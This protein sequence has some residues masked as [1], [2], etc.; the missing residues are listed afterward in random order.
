[1]NYVIVFFND[2]TC[3]ENLTTFKKSIFKCLPLNKVV[4]VNTKMNNITIF[5]NHGKVLKETQLEV[6]INTEME[7]SGYNAGLKYLYEHGKIDK[8]IVLNDTVFSHGK[9]RKCEIIALIEYY[10]LSILFNRESKLKE[11]KNEKII[12]GFKHTNEFLANYDF[13]HEYVNSKFFI[14]KNIDISDFEE[15]NPIGHICVEVINGKYKNNIY[16]YSGYNEFLSEWLNG[17]KGWYKA[18][19]L[20]NSNQGFFI[21]KAKSI[22]HEH[23]MSDPKN[24]DK[25]KIK[26]ICIMKKSILIKLISLLIGFKY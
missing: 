26:A 22:V 18:E 17:E 13:S 23:F 14:L 16:N 25:Y 6:S 19:R 9:F 5:D 7:F 12:T 4:I 21:R 1:M 24:L 8:C 3:R 2:L 20:N 15:L 11:R 10:I